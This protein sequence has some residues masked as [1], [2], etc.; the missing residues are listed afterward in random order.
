MPPK[1]KARN[2]GS[3]FTTFRYAGKNIAYLEVV[4]DSGQAPVAQVQ[5]VHP[6]GHRH[7]I[8]FVTPRAVDYGTLVLSIRELWNEEIWEQMVGL[9]GAKDIVDVFQR[10]AEQDNY[11]TCSKI[12]TPPSGP[13]YGKTYHRCVISNISDGEEF[14]I[15]S[16]SV[17][18]TITIAYTHTTP[19]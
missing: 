12:I 6:L 3:N 8:E 10:L 11:V 16:M 1:Q 15:S 2:L 9:T 19:L 17:P 4:R 14:S 18:K 13:K 5:A 7:P